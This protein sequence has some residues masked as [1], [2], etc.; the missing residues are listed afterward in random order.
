[1]DLFLEHLFNITWFT[2][3]PDTW[4]IF[5]IVYFASYTY[6]VATNSCP[7]ISLQVHW[8]IWLIWYLQ[9]RPYQNVDY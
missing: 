4:P 3:T 5:Q 2:S 7:N 1:M 8:L 6:G 9:Y